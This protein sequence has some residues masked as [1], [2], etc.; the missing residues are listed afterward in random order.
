MRVLIQRVTSSQVVAD[1]EV[2]GSIN[3]GLNLLVG[4][5]PTDTESELEWMAQKCLN[6][7]LFPEGSDGRFDLSVTELGGDLLVVSQFTLY[8]DGRKGR[9]PSFSKAAPPVLAESLYERFVEILRQSGLKVETGR[10]GAM[11]QVSIENDGPVTL[12][13]EKESDVAMKG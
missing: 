11:M 1:G 13:L 10:F 12:W 2:V 5:G 7:R 6:L 4:I 8:G 9:R 3:R